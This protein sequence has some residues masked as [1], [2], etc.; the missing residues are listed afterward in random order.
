MAW[1]RTLFTRIPSGYLARVVKYHALAGL[2]TVVLD[3]LRELPLV[4]EVLIRIL[5]QLRPWHSFPLPY[6]FANSS[7]LGGTDW[8]LTVLGILA[9]VFIGTLSHGFSAFLVH[10]LVFPLSAWKH[11]FFG[12]PGYWGEVRER[13]DLPA[14]WAESAKSSWWV[15]PV[16]AATW[17]LIEEVRSSL[18]CVWYPVIPSGILWDSLSLL[19]VVLLYARSQSRLLQAEIIRAVNPED[20]RCTRCGYQL[21][22]LR[23]LRCPECGS[24]ADRDGK[25]RYD[26]AWSMAGRLSR[27]LRVVSLLLPAVL[28]LSSVW[29]PSVVL[30]LPRAWIYYLPA[31]IQPSWQ[32][33]SVD[34]NAFPIRLDSVCVVRHGGALG[35]VRFRQFAPGSVAHFEIGYWADAGGFGSKPPDRKNAG[36]IWNGGGPGLPL[37]PWD[38]AYGMAG[39]NMI[40]LRRPDATYEVQA[41]EPE[42][43]PGDLSWLSPVSQ[44]ASQP[45]SRPV[46]GR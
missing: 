26:F 39:E 43:F 4:H 27:I 13:L 29:V 40:W 19:A 7:P 42:H 18:V 11:R 10:G 35:V 9:V 32:V 25:V 36:R 46:H 31:A 14:V 15:W 23:E 28:L 2:I 6:D 44:P 21:R 3:L 5:W 41:F 24:E 45:S 12:W 37:G 16:A 1:K 20:L 38:F 30:S 22:G 17:A 33:L 8:L 34:Y